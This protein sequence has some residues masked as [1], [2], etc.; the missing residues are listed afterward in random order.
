MINKRI[1]AA[2][3]VADK[4]ASQVEAAQTE[5]RRLNAGK[6]DSRGVIRKELFTPG[7]LDLN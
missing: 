5:I 4:V 3:A 6:A 7:P 2:L 1:D